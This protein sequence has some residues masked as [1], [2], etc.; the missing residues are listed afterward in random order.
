MLGLPCGGWRRGGAKACKTQNILFGDALLCYVC[1]TP[2]QAVRKLTPALLPRNFS[3]VSFLRTALAT[4]WT[5]VG[6][7]RDAI[8]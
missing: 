8:G 5:E 7:W 6:T 3:R 4:N 1:V 2:P